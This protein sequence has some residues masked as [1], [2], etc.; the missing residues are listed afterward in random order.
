MPTNSRK[1]STIVLLLFLLTT[2]LLNSGCIGTIAAITII[3]NKQIAARK[4]KEAEAPC[5]E[6]VYAES[7]LTPYKHDNPPPG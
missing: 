1:V 7:E 6:K 4:A 3:S 2:L 5:V